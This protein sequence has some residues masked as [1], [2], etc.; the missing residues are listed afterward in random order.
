MERAITRTRLC[1]FVHFNAVMGERPSPITCSCTG[2]SSHDVTDNASVTCM[3]T[4]QFT[5]A[6]PSVKSEGSAPRVSIV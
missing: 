1:S 3:F 2:V 5:M 6:R 4:V